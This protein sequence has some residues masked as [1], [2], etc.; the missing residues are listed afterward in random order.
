VDRAEL[1]EQI[2][3]AARQVASRAFHDSPDLRDLMR[4]AEADGFTVSADLVLTYKPLPTKSK[5][6]PIALDELA[7]LIA[8]PAALEELYQLEDTREEN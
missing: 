1:R 4:Q 8:S 7:N 5:P 2:E 6:A 3:I